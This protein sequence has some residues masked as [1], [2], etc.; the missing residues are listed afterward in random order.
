VGAWERGDTG[1]DVAERFE[2]GD[3]DLP[4]VPAD[5]GGGEKRVCNPNE[6]DEGDDTGLPPCGGKGSSRVGE[7]GL[8]VR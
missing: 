1:D 2:R 8:R 3:R 5:D 6:E 4:G 7:T